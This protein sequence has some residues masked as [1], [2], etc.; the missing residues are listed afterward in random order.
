MSLLSTCAGAQPWRPFRHSDYPNN[1]NREGLAEHIT[2]QMRGMGVK[3]GPGGYKVV[4][5]LGNKRLLQ[6]IGGELCW[7]WLSQLNLIVCSHYS[8]SPR[9]IFL[10]FWHCLSLARLMS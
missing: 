10:S 5:V 2:L 6:L 3:M 1:A 4:D 7:G 9:S 8:S